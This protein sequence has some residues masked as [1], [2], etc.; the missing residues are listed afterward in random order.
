[1]ELR[2][3]WHIV[4][5]RVWIPA[6]L[7]VI[8]LVF[9]L[10]LHRAPPPQYQATARVLVDVPPLEAVEGMGFDPRLTAPQAT[11]YLVDD[12]SLF[13]SSQAVAELVSSRLADRGIQV[14]A[15]VVQSSTASEQVHRVVTVRATW[16]DPEGAMAILNTTVDVLRQEAPSYF[17][18]LG[19]ESPQITLF[20]GPGV[21][22]VP[23]SLT[24]RL[25]L[26]LRLLLALIAGVALCFFLDYLDDSIRGREEL[27]SLDIPVLAEVPGRRRYFGEK[28]IAL[29]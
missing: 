18:R 21:G 3:Y 10:A 6:L 2:Q 14:P 29:D 20:D 19:Q 28:D 17:G 27:E 23:P 12:F 9:S 13:V 16:S 22:P 4:W 15:G 5:K 1:M 24:Q 11:E 8:V 25:D 26:P 7:L